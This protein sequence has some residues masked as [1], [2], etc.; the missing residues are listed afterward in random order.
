MRP[1]VAA[2]WIGGRNAAVAV[3]GR[4][5]TAGAWLRRGQR[6]RCPAGSAPGAAGS[7]VAFRAGGK[8]GAACAEPGACQGG[9]PGGEL[10]TRTWQQT[11]EE[12]AGRRVAPPALANSVAR[13]AGC[14]TFPGRR[15]PIGR[16]DGRT[17]ASG[18]RAVGLVPAGGSGLGR[19]VL[20]H[21]PQMAEIG[22]AAEELR[23]P[24]ARDGRRAGKL[25][26]RRPGRRLPSGIPPNHAPGC[27]CSLVRC[28]AA[29]CVLRTAL[30][31][32]CAPFCP[33]EINRLVP[34]RQALHCPLR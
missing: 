24:D 25:P 14:G 32:G 16:S 1:A 19:R 31:T 20:M 7:S 8:P 17:G 26:V 34:G 18:S 22:R 10:R 21:G 9:A 13:G 4:S 28:P 12:Q 30:A 2:V 27:V 33:Q 5:S 29:S 6:A 3:V 11:P 23:A 15:A